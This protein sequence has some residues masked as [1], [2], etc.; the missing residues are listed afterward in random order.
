MAEGTS[1]V[2]HDAALTN[3][4]AW[5]IAI[6]FITGF[7]LLALRAFEIKSDRKLAEN[8]SGGIGVFGLFA[9]WVLSLYVAVKYFTYSKDGHEFSLDHPIKIQGD[10][11]FL[12]TEGAVLK[13]GILLDPLSVIFLLALTTIATVIHFYATEYMHADPAYTRFFGTMNFFTGS[14]IGFV[15]ASNLFMGFIFWELLGVTSYLLIGYFWPK[16]SAAHAAKKAFLYNKVGDTSFLIGIALIFAKTYNMGHMTLDYVE[17]AG[18]IGNEL[19]FS[20][21]ALPGLLIFGGAVGKS[22]QFPLFGWLPEA[23]EGPTPVSSLLH[24]STMV[25]AGLFLM[26]RTFFMIY[27]GHVDFEHHIFH[28][29]FAEIIVWVGLLTALMGALMALTATDIKR[30]LAFST[31]SQLGYIGLAIGSGG[32]TAGFFHILSHATFKSLLFLCAGSVIHSV[33]SQEITDMGGLKKYMP[34]T[35]YTTLIGL[36][37]LAGFPLMNGFWSKDAIL[38]AIKENDQI[39]LNELVWGIA[40]FTAGITAFYSTKL[41]ILTFLGEGRYDK[42]HVHPSPTGIR[43]RISLVILASLVVI[44]SLWWTIGAISKSETGILNFEP[45]LA[46][47]MGNH[48]PEFAW[49]DAVPS[50]IAVFAGIGLSFAIYYYKVPGFVGLLTFSVTQFF[51]KM[52]ENRFGL[53]KFLYWFAE[54]PVM[55]A[56]DALVYVDKE[57]IDAVIIDK[58][59]AEGTLKAAEASDDFD[60][61]IIDGFIDWLGNRTTDIGYRLRSLQKGQTPMYARFMTAGLMVILLVITV[62]NINF[63][64]LLN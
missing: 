34:W 13:W 27:D 24:S 23:M 28:F 36:L 59:A 54:T 9:S 43:M 16:A 26:A 17:L 58:I 33:H 3:M 52:A 11:D 51:A 12:P 19:S 37:G 57:I 42:D 46:N 22:A 55:A 60:Q 1:E 10:Y 21:I 5:I 2:L 31:V 48:G 25:K 45:A 50:M 4:A 56:G 62:A 35:Y 32:L 18:M 38:I 63:D 8:L 29:D 20:D 44:E 64:L 47:M 61:G 41:L 30:V 39:W 7:L 15:L 49:I 40:V 14:M 6:P 53:D